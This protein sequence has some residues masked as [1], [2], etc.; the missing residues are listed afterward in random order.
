MKTEESLSVEKM[1]MIL[2]ARIIH[3]Q[4]KLDNTV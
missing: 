3:D 2:L 1:K 4:R